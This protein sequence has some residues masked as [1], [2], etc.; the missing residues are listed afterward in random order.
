MKSYICLL[1]VFVT[2]SLCSLVG[3][4]TTHYQTGIA[5]KTLCSQ[6]VRDGDG[7]YASEDGSIIMIGVHE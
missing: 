7:Y 1:T 4:S 2:V 6:I 3:C 5:S